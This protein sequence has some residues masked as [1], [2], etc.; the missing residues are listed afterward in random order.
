M[1]G[2]LSIKSLDA[3]INS[4]ITSIKFASTVMMKAANEGWIELKSEVT[5]NNN[6]EEVNLLTVVAGNS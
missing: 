5:K 1:G 3:S 6:R 4:T 2:I